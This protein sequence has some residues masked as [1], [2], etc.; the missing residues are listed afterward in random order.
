MCAR[1]FPTTIYLYFD[2]QTINEWNLSARSDTESA[3]ECVC[4]LLILILYPKARNIF[5]SS[6]TSQESFPADF[7]PWLFPPAPSLNYS[8]FDHSAGRL[9]PTRQEEAYT[10]VASATGARGL[11][12]Q[13]TDAKQLHN[14]PI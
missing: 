7:S 3:C 1:I 8:S 9:H 12:G 11:V 6:R 14:S 2:F 13:P 5:M 10:C 4:A